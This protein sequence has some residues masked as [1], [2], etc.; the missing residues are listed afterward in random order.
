MCYM[1]QIKL[2]LKLVQMWKVD[3]KLPSLH[4]ALLF[5]VEFFRGNRNFLG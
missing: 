5:R 4:A 2:L 1:F 3:P